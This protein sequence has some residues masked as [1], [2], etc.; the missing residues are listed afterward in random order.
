VPTLPVLNNEQR[1]RAQQEDRV[2]LEGGPLPFFSRGSVQL[3]WY[4]PV[5]QQSVILGTIS[6][7][8]RAQAQFRL[9]GSGGE[10]LEVPYRINLD[11]GLTAIS[12]AYVE[13]MQ[14]AGYNESVEAYVF[15]TPEIAPR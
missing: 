11:Y 12:P 7:D 2:V 13:R 14:R 8:F 1:W 15:L 5:A 4:D 6:G 10:A 9:K 3:W